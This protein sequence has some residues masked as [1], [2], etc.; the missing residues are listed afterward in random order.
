MSD[1][2]FD[3]PRIHKTEDWVMNQVDD[4]VWEYVCEFYG[5]DDPTEL[6]DDQIAEID[7]FRTD[8]LNE[9]SVLQCGFSNIINYWES[10]SENYE[11]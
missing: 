2:S 3:W 8:E 1:N 11:L 4:A 6:T 7:H 10:N 5:V 9:Y